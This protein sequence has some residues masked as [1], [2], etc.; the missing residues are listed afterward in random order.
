MCISC[1]VPASP[2]ELDPRDQNS[3]ALDHISQTPSSW[4]SHPRNTISSCRHHSKLSVYVPRCMGYHNPLSSNPT[5]CPRPPLVVG[6]RLACPSL[7][8]KAWCCQISS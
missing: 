8:R 4:A 5:R 3:T 7:S 1:T 2:G 6:K